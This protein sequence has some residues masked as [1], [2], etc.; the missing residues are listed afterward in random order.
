MDTRQPAPCIRG[1]F[2]SAPDALL[3]F[4]PGVALLGVAVAPT[5]LRRRK[6]LGHG[7]RR[8]LGLGI[9]RHKRIAPLTTGPRH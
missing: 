4:D 3:S 7:A 8:H 1:F 2:A 9:G 6:L 5:D